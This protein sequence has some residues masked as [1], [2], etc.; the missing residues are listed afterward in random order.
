MRL[1]KGRLSEGRVSAP[2]KAVVLAGLT[3]AL[4]SFGVGASPFASAQSG[5]DTTATPGKPGDMNISVSSDEKVDADGTQGSFTPAI[6]GA[7]DSDGDQD[8]F[9]HGSWEA[10]PQDKVHEKGH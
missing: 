1:N 4:I 6:Q 8:A 5:T 9:D 10:T 3:A 7:E 2:A